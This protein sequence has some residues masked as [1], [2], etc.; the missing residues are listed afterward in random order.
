MKI[1]STFLHS[2]CR[3]GTSAAGHLVLATILLAPGFSMATP[4]CVSGTLASVISTG[5]CT[6]GDATFDFTTPAFKSYPWYNGPYAGD[7]AYGPSASQVTF[8]P[9]FSATSAGFNLAGPFNVG[10]GS[11]ADVQFGYVKVSTLTS[12]IVG[13]NLAIEGAS[14]SND[15][16]DNFI[17]VNDA[18]H[19]YAYGSGAV[20]HLSD[21]AALSAPTNLLWD[22]LFT[23]TWNYGNASY[24]G[25]TDFTYSVNLQSTAPV[26]PG[27]SVP[28][29]ATLAL[30]SLALAGLAFTRRNRKS[31]QG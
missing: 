31:V 5:S 25:F 16:P 21:S 22:I 10:A 1:N 6:I 9:V 13:V 20:L 7:N 27:T 2:P 18:G 26:D 11:R 19:V 28:E 17:M 14:V 15:S 29:P 4:A 8:T 30:S 12:L 23:R 3:V 24:L